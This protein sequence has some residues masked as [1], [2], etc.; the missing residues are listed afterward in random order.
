[1][2]PRALPVALALAALAAT[3][4][5]GSGNHERAHEAA[6]ANATLVRHKVRTDSLLRTRMVLPRFN[7]A[8]L[9]R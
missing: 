9:M 6:V 3:A 1:M 2:S 8:L 7:D 5:C 4:G